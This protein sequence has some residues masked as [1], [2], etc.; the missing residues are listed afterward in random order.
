MAVI[1]LTDVSVRIGSRQIL[2]G[3]T[4]P[5]LVPGQ[6]VG[7]IGPNASGKSTLLRTI[8]IGSDFGGTITCDGRDVR[9]M[10]ARDRSG[11]IALMPQSPPQGS[12]LSPFELMRSYARAM[13]LPLSDVELDR[14]MADLLRDLG[15]LAE[16]HRPLQELSGGK[17][18]LVG[19]CLALMREPQLLLL[20]EP[21]SALDLRWQ[22]AAVRLSRSYVEAAQAI[23][24]I[25]V[26]DINLAL[27]FC[28]LLIVLRDGRVA[29]CG[30]PAEVVTP[31]LIAYVY[32]VSARMERCSAGYPILISDEPIPA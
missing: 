19:L 12:A 24:I 8:A 23:A 27:R 9:A 11:V 13:D 20:D 26:H 18:Q 16:A 14:R 1:S 15:L 10:K 25:A 31:D 29:A 21:T 3:V 32:G 17:R 28:D 4:V 5:D 22:L 30:T 6:V 7:L 2:H